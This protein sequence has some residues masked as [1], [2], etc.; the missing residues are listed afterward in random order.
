MKLKMNDSYYTEYSRKMPPG[1]VF[2]AGLII[3]AAGLVLVVLSFM[4]DKTRSSFNMLISFMFLMS[5]AV[6]SLFLVALEYLGGAVWSTPVRRV[7][8]LLSSTLII[9]P[10]IAAVLLFNMPDL[11]HW[12]H[13]EAV[14]HDEVLQAKSPY[15]NTTFFTVRSAVILF[16]W[17]LF[18]YL[19]RRNSL[20]QDDTRDYSLTR[21]S[22]KISAV[23]MPVFGL[24]ITF[25]AIDWMMT[26][27]PHWF[28]TIFGVYYFAGTVVA[29][30]AAATLI[31]VLLKENGYLHPAMVDDHYYSLGALMF[32][33]VNF[34]A[35]IAF[36]QFLLIWY[37]NLP[38]ENFW[39]IQRWKDDWQFV[40]AL[41]IIM[42]FVVPYFALLSQP[43]KMNPRRL[44]FV[45]IWLLCA[46]FLDLYWIIMPTYGKKDAVF[47]WMEIAFPVAVVGIIMLIFIY[48]ARKINLV[49][50]GDP[51]LKSGLDFRL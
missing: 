1:R 10:L 35:Y 46:H 19:L 41:L 39:F 3:L 49:P 28:S 27:E 7:S 18:Y 45:S 36:S 31:S 22:I 26:L 17:L 24:S 48:Q 47:G 11:Y 37:A 4:F 34:W 6:G 16:L 42:H 38:E 50:I 2:T 29:A 21:K 14:S 30:L 44:T 40:S 15:L 9:L 43:S 25:A 23:F 33:F 51:K 32:G 13:H 20:R 8:E 12:A 5:I